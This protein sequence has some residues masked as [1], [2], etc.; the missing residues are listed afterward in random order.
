[1][2]KTIRSHIIRKHIIGII[3]HAFLAIAIVGIAIWDRQRTLEQLLGSI[4]GIAIAPLL[5]IIGFI[6][7]S[8]YLAD[9]LIGK[10][11]AKLLDRQTQN[12]IYPGIPIN[13]NDDPKTERGYNAGP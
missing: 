2:Q 13:E 11:I 4:Q 9:Q 8:V 5:G 7:I 10:I 1:M 12:I 3:I 6:I